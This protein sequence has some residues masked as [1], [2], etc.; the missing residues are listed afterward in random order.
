[1]P[2]SCRTLVS[3][4]AVFLTATCL[5][6]TP[7]NVDTARL[8][9]V[10]Q[11]PQSLPREDPGPSVGEMLSTGEPFTLED[12]EDELR[13][14]SLGG[15]LGYRYSTSSLNWIPGGGDQFGMFSIATWNTLPASATCVWTTPSCSAW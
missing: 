5:A 12:L 15:F 14:A 11:S 8:P 13:S 3:L 6:Q 9:S 7:E 10:D 4:L 1:M 2:R